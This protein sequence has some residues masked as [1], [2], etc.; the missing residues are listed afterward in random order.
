VCPGSTRC[1]VFAGDSTTFDCL[2]GCDW[3]QSNS[4]PSGQICQPNHAD[5]ARG[6]TCALAC[7][8]TNACPTTQAGATYLACVS[9]LCKC[10]SDQACQTAFS[11]TAR[12]DTA[13]G[14]CYDPCTSNTSC[15]SGCCES[16]ASGHPTSCFYS[17]RGATP[18][19]A[20]CAV[21]TDCATGYCDAATGKC[22]TS[23]ACT[24]FECGQF[25]STSTCGADQNCS[26]P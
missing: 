20:A 2:P 7:S 21:N 8:T 1:D 6:G 14:S 9:G 18:I 26:C 22:N 12:C 15:N 3:T 25:S 11:A 10:T 24:A 23:D 5:P 4:C 17:Q 19:C 13:S 16:A